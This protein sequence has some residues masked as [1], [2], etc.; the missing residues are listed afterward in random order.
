[1]RSSFQYSLANLD[2]ISVA[3]FDQRWDGKANRTLMG[4][5]LPATKRL[6]LFS[7]TRLEDQTM[8]LSIEMELEAISIA[9]IRATRDHVR[10]LLVLKPD[11]TLSVLT[12]GLYELPLQLAPRDTGRDASAMDVD[13]ACQPAASA[14][15]II[16]I[17]D[18]ID[19]S[20]T[21]TYSD[22]SSIRLTIDLMPRD[23][24][25]RQCL[26]MMAVT[27][28]KDSCFALHSCFLRKWSRRSFSNLDNVE[29]DSFASALCETFELDDPAA[30]TA[31]VQAGNSTPWHALSASTSFTRFR[32]DPV[33]KKLILPPTSSA[34]LSRPMRKPHPLLPAIL[35]AL[36]NVAE[37]LRLMVSNY[38]ALMR[39][40]PV[41]CKIA[42][43][44]RPEWVDFWK[45]LCPDAV[46]VWPSPHTEGEWP[47]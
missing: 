22:D 7:L 26:R 23:T 15:T 35:A 39:L 19:S 29:F 42:A 14:D 12:H 27:L 11:G 2:S 8:A 34:P 33:L 32:E 30:T 20:V 18:V 9:S 44:I 17:K 21:V 4:V 24:L 10:D 13:E 47:S 38:H 36:Q 28:P 43:I 3:L 5:C 40:I 6:F 31:D 37:D 16:G 45:R 25:A 46:E 41:I 1:M